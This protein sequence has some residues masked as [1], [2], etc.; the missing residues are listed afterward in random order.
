M[1][2]TIGTMLLAEDLAAKARYTDAVRLID[3]ILGIPAGAD[4]DARMEAIRAAFHSTESLNDSFLE[5]LSQAA[6][7]EEID[8]KGYMKATINPRRVPLNPRLVSVSELLKKR[9]LWTFDQVGVAQSV[10]ALESASCAAQEICGLL[11]DEDIASQ[12][13]LDDQAELLILIVGFGLAARAFDDLMKTLLSSAV[14]RA[15]ANEKVREVIRMSFGMTSQKLQNA[16][17]E[18][19]DVYQ[20]GFDLLSNFADIASTATEILSESGGN[21]PERKALLKL[22]ADR[23]EEKMKAERE[24]THV[25][26]WGKSISIAQ[27]LGSVPDPPHRA[28]SDSASA[29]N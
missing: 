13:T 20:A 5:E 24:Y 9:A 8:G 1:K 22:I 27:H 3:Q 11:E 25:S 16:A 21:I 15:P 7:V 6:T 26:R 28:L 17:R 4:A 10:E 2:G 18:M 12:I 29:S 23:M 14:L 19:R